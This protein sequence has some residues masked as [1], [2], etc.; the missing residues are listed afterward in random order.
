M[1]TIPLPILMGF[2]I[3]LILIPALTPTAF[4]LGIVDKPSGR[5]RHSHDTPVHGGIAI[6]LGFSVACL[7]EESLLNYAW[8]LLLISLFVLILGAIDDVKNLS[9]TLR[10]LLQ[11]TLALILTVSTDTRILSL[12]IYGSDG[13]MTLDIMSTPFTVFCIVA[14]VNAINMVDGIDGLA[15]MLCMTILTTITI[16]AYLA[17]Q[18]YLAL[19]TLTLIA[20]LSAFLVFNMP[21]PWHRQASVFMGDAGSTFLGFVIVWLLIK[22]TQGPQAIFS[23]AIGIWLLT[24]PLIDSGST[25]IRRIIAKKSPLTAGRDHHHHWLLKKG[26]SS[27]QVCYL[28]TAIS[29]A[30][31]AV[32]YGLHTLNLPQGILVVIFFSCLAIDIC[33]LKKTLEARQPQ[34]QAIKQQSDTV[35]NRRRRIKPDQR[36]A[37]RHCDDD[38]ESSE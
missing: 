8:P 14:G 3:S 26:L 22:A 15:G 37:S 20:A 28:L 9:A 5:K 18:T 2:F 34:R 21:L 24:V 36:R 29:A 1:E 25:I 30:I 4:K 7:L 31:C 27:M 10:L 35:K 17:Q 33:L 6:F 16:A 12:G 19:F 13:A 11:A 38:D 32:S 23:P